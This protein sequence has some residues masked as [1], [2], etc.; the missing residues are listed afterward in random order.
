MSPRRTDDVEMA[1]PIERPRTPG[2][3]PINLS[4]IGGN[5]VGGAVKGGKAVGSVLQDFKNFLNRG[6]VV[7]LAVGI[8]MGA[9]FTAVVASIVQD[10][11]TP[12]I[13]LAL[14]S[15]LENKFI[16]LKC[17]VD[18]VTNRVTDCRAVQNTLRKWNTTADAQKDGAVTWNWGKFLQ[19]CLNFIIIAAVVFFIIKAYT[20]A[21]RRNNQPAKSKACPYCCKDIP[22]KATRCPECTSQLPDPEV[23]AVPELP[24]PAM[25]QVKDKRR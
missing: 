11:F 17:P 16:I 2:G 10:L 23:P 6:N 19:T 24:S 12:L 7:D 4:K 15:N 13:G 8:V 9:A 3:T 25:T 5:V 14:Q 21:F 22:V 20:A 18:P 1:T